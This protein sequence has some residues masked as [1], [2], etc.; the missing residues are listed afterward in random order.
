MRISV[1]IPVY[2]EAVLIAGLVKYLQ[3]HGGSAVH[4][5]IVCDGGSADDTAVNARAAGATVL[6][7]PQKG[8]AA[9]M[10]F[11]AAAATGDV[12][13]FVHADTLP[14]PQFAADIAAAVAAGYALGRCRSRFDTKSWLMK[15]TAWFT[16]FDW[17]VCMGGDQTLFVTADLFKKTGGYNNDMLIMEEYEFCS[18]AKKL[19]RYKIFASAALIST[20]KYIGR[21]WWQVQKANYRAVKLYKKGTPHSEIAAVYQQWLQQ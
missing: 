4:E 21:S 13:Y 3:Q 17:F 11:A 12:L 8:R 14:P 2:N 16:R 20:R 15:L 18:K 7:A 5:I 6:A 19:G 10:N 1:V 9:Q